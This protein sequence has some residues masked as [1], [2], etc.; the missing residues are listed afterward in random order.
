MF[1]LCVGDLD[2]LQSSTQFILERN[3]F[4]KGAFS[5]QKVHPVVILKEL[6]SLS[7]ESVSSFQRKAHSASLSTE[8][9]E[10]RKSS[11][12][13]LHGTWEQIKLPLS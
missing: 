3:T 8:E 10:T 12:R 5:P 2:S 7:R 11:Q 4:I 6:G 13:A 1:Q 9:E